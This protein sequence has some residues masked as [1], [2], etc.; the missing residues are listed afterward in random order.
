[1]KKLKIMHF[2]L[3]FL[4]LAVTLASLPWLP[5]QIPAHYGFNG[6]VDRWGSKYETFLFPAIALFF[7]ALMLAMAKYSAKNEETG[8]NNEKIGLLAGAASLG[9][10]NALHAVFMYTSFA[11]VENLNQMSLEFNQIA[12]IAYGAT[13]IV[14][15]NIMPKSKPNSVVGVRTAWS[16]K[17]EIT[18]KKSQRFGGIISIIC[19]VVLVLACLF[20]RGMAC[21]F[22][23]MGLTA[24][25]VCADLI[26][27]YRACRR[28]G[29][30]KESEK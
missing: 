1:M 19:G 26:Y 13:L 29:A 30:E 14:V 21:F 2:I 10:F 23:A 20:V 22:L 18:W 27:S 12:F 6:E 11:Q 24:V 4:P 7:G 9:L 8:R 25:M 3:M 5:D 16:M 15:G 28:Y 17:N